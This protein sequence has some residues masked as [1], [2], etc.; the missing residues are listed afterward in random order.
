MQNSLEFTIE[1]VHFIEGGH[2]V[3]FYELFILMYSVC[4]RSEYT[5]VRSH[6]IYSYEYL[7]LLLIKLIV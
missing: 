5:P 6:L 3:G 7:C 1:A 4:S 2:Y